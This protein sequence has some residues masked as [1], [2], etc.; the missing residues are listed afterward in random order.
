MAVTTGLVKKLGLKGGMKL[1]LFRAPE[2]FAA[3]LDE[4]P[5][6]VT[7]ATEVTSEPAAF[8]AA[9]IFVRT[10]DEIQELAPPGI[11][12]TKPTGHLWFAYPKK[13]GTIASDISRDIGWDAVYA[14]GYRP[15]AQVA[16]DQTWTGFRFRPQELFQSR[17]KN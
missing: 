15:V 6:G 7:V 1:L 11:R 8:D 17:R 3:A 16:I 5:P 2:P 12:A 13:T 9:L 10:Q 4:L 14:K